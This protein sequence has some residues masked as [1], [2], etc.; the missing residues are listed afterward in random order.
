MIRKS[1]SFAVG[2]A[3]A[4]K[5]CDPRWR[6]VKSMVRGVPSPLARLSYKLINIKD[7]KLTKTQSY[8]QG[9][10]S[11]VAHKGPADWNL[12]VLLSWQMLLAG[13]TGRV[14]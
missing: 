12:R 2:L 4:S 11:L 7:N 14:G 1:I 3:G 9:P 8:K 5:S 6:V 13:K 10:H